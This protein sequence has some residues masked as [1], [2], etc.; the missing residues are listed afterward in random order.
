MK[1]NQRKALMTLDRT[2]DVVRKMRNQREKEYTSIKP[3]WCANSEKPKFRVPMISYKWK[4]GMGKD[5]T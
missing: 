5:R 4:N 1:T 2:Y 3:R